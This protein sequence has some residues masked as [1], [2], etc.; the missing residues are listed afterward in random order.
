MERAASTAAEKRIGSSIRKIEYDSVD[1]R[2]C[3]VILR[4]KSM[5]KCSMLKW[6]KDN[7]WTARCCA[8]LALW[9]GRLAPLM[10]LD[11]SCQHTMFTP[12][13]GVCYLLMRDALRVQCGY[14]DFQSSKNTIPGKSAIITQLRDLVC[15]ATEP[16]FC[17]F[18]V[19]KRIVSCLQMA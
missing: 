2:N 14:N 3:E 15:P 4:Y 7:V 19:C 8:A 10:E 17:T 12:E 13:K 9:L 11:D 6:K 5:S 16:Q 18:P 1:W